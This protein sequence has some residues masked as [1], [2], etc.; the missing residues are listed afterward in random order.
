MPQYVLRLTHASDQCP[1]SNSKIRERVVRSSPEM[2][3]LA[4]KLGVKFVAGPYVLG[5]EHES[6]A[7]MEA[8]SVE[9]IEDFLM[10]SGSIQ[11]NSVKVSPAKL[12]Q[13]ALQDL[14][15]CPPAIY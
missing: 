13:E 4:Q 5:A 2:P 8:E 3:K 7:V 14:D 10:Q 1:T 12:L 11:W 6:V 15:D 9:V